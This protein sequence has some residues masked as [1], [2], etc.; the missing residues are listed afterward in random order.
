[1]SNSNN[2]SYFGR[3]IALLI[4]AVPALGVIYNTNFGAISTITKVLATIVFFGMAFMLLAKSISNEKEAE[5]IVEY[6]KLLGRMRFTEV[7]VIGLFLGIWFSVPTFTKTI[8]RDY[9]EKYQHTN[10]GGEKTIFEQ[11]ASALKEKCQYTK[12][13]KTIFEQAFCQ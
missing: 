4:F 2:T 10:G 9:Q 1:M 13:E 11:A 12:G 8:D 6:L 5:N 3:L 7:V